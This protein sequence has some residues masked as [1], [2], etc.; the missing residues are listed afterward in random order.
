MKKKEVLEL[1]TQYLD[2][3]IKHYGESKFYSTTP[4]LS[5]E[6]SKYS[7][8]QDSYIKGEFCHVL[9]EITIYWKNILSEEE[10]F[11]T[12]I[13]EYVHYLQSPTWMTRYYKKGYRYDTHPYEV[14]AYREEQNWKI[15]SYA[16]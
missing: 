15:I 11:R 2:K 5:V 13:H 9:N 8:T 6:N 4:Y 10:L 16:T 7:D 14:Q 3:V 12:L 1:S